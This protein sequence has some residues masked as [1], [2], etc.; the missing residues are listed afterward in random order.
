MMTWK[1]FIVLCTS[2][3]TIII[4]VKIAYSCLPEQIYYAYPSFFGNK[5]TNKPAYRPFYYVAEDP[6][7]NNYDDNLQDNSD[8]LNQENIQDWKHYTKADI[9]LKDI[10]SLVNKYTIQDIKKIAVGQVKMLASDKKNNAF[11]QWLLRHSAAAVINYMIYAKQ[12]EPYVIPQSDW[13][14]LVTNIDSSQILIRTGLALRHNTTDKFLKARYTFQVLRLAFYNKRYDQTLHLFDSLIGTFDPKTAMLSDYRSLGLKAGVYYRTKNYPMATY[15]YAKMFDGPDGLKNTAMISFVWSTSR[16]AKQNK[17]AIIDSAFQL[18][19]NDHER[20]VITVMQALRS[21]DKALPLIKKAYALDPNIKGIDVLVNREI[22]KMEERY[23]QHGINQT[24]HIEYDSYYYYFEGRPADKQDYLMDSLISTYPGYLGALNSFSQQM[25]REQ[26]AGN[27]AFWH[28]A[29]AYISYMLNDTQKMNLEMEKAK[30]AGMQ[31]QE[32]QLYQV[33]KILQTIK[34]HSTITSLEESELLP[35]LK[36]LDS[37]SNQNADQDHNF[38]CIMNLLLAPRYLAQKDTIKALYCMAHSKRFKGQSYGDYN[39]FYYDYP[40]ATSE[41]NVDT[42]LRDRPGQI[43]D[44]ISLKSIQAMQAFVDSSHYSAFNSWLVSGTYYTQTMLKEMEGTKYLRAFKFKT[45][46]DILKDN[47]NLDSLAYP[48][49]M[50]INDITD[51][52][53]QLDSTHIT[54]KWTF[55]KQMADL[56]DII[57]K[58]TDN[59]PALYKY[60]LGLYGMSYYGRSP[61]LFSYFRSTA[62]EYKYYKTKQRDQLPAPFQ[63][64]YGLYTAEKYFNLA[65]KVAKTNTLKAKCIFGAAKCWQK[66]CT[67]TSKIGYSDLN[68]VGYSLTNPYFKILKTQYGSNEF[69][70]AIYNTCSYYRDFIRKN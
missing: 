4:A 48:F 13:D 42:H 6:F 43:L 5:A 31:P 2:I 25:I 35:K 68:Y 63:Q 66:R 36:T 58:D 12:C 8:I 26:K 65:A 1:K 33:F 51:T 30:T 54:T 57:K 45:A 34:D 56:Q 55:A 23:E 47:T 29:C 28:L 21:N 37:L 32:A 40:E 52:I 41:Y 49:E 46:A 3:V 16:W 15:L 64:Y 38:Y 14:T 18:C 27:P 11:T 24:N 60:A 53:Y 50:H 7:Y 67:R 39:W 20:A 61:N 69:S 22:N 70:K 59:A 17:T 10:D 9:P 19:K 44:K 62:D